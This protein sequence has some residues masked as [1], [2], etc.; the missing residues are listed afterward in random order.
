MSHG[1]VYKHKSNHQ[2]VKKISQAIEIIGCLLYLCFGI[3][4]DFL[5]FVML[6]TLLLVFSFVLLAR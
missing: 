6:L 1:G 4:L 2:T 5:L 3:H